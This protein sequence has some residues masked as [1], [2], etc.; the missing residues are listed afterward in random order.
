MDE[1]GPLV[2]GFL[3]LLLIPAIGVANLTRKRLTPL[4]ALVVAAWGAVGAWAL[5]WSR[6]VVLGIPRAR[7]LRLWIAG[8]ILGFGFLL[9]ARLR[10]RR[11]TWRWIK[12]AMVAAT[13]AAFAKG[14]WT[15]LHTYA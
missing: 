4:L 10:E 1:L 13:L 7:F 2:I 14:L 12:L 15:Y 8:L 11:K 3:T 6:P 9:V 5:L